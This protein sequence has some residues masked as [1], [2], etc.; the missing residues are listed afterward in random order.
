MVDLL[1]S[2]IAQAIAELFQAAI[3]ALAPI[4][5][6]DMSLF[7][8]TFPFAY[9]AYGIFQRVALA[10]VLVIAVVHL[11][12]WFFPS[13]KQSKVSPIRIAFSAIVATI[14]IFY[15]NY[16]FEAIIELCKYPYDALLNSDAT[17]AR[18][19]AD[20][21]FNG[22]ATVAADAFYSISV[23]LYIVIIL[24]I[25]I[26]F[27]KLMVEAIERYCILYYYVDTVGKYAYNNVMI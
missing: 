3:Q 10:L 26:A 22:I 12:P 17:G 16:L 20:F 4:L 27:L 21:E 7:N 11:W 5:G 1:V 23:P 25:G 6:F 19:I 14:F 8:R 18:P 13:D 2:W 15:G 9:T 24:L